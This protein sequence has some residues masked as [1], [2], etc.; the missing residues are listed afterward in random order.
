MKLLHLKDQTEKYEVKAID[1]LTISVKVYDIQKQWSNLQNLVQEVANDDFEGIVV[2]TKLGSTSDYWGLEFCMRLRLSYSL[3]GVKAFTTLFVYTESPVEEMIKEQ[4]EQKTQ[5]TA[6]LLLTKGTF[7]F[8]SIDLFTVISIPPSNYNQLNE[9]NYET[10]FL[11]VIRINKPPEVGHHSLANLFGATRLAEITG[12]RHLIDTNTA[13]SEKK[14]DLYFKF[15]TDFKS[16]VYK[17]SQKKTIQA[18]GKK[19]LLIDDKENFGWSD[20]LKEIFIGADFYSVATGENFVERAERQS[21]ELVNE[22]IK[23]DLILLDLRLKDEEDFNELVN[24]HSSEYSGAK[25]L[26]KIKGQNRGVQVIVFTAS[27]KA[28]NLKELIQAPYYADGYF[29]KESPEISI[30]AVFSTKAYQNFEIQVEECFIRKFLKILKRTVCNIKLQIK[31]SLWHDKLTKT[32]QL[33]IG[34]F[35]GFVISILDA[36]FEILSTINKIN[37]LTKL[38]HAFLLQYQILEEYVKLETIYQ[39]GKNKTASIVFKKDK[40]SVEVYGPDMQ[41]SGNVK[42]NIAFKKG[43][44]DYQTLESDQT[45]K[46]VIFQMDTFKIGVNS[47]SQTNETT[48]FKIINVFKERHHY[49]EVECNKLIELTYL[50]SNLCGHITGN[51]KLDK[52]DITKDDIIDLMNQI[53]NIVL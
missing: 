27:N 20:V 6:T 4:T 25:L 37:S 52:R 18:D 42:C 32:Q 51:V 44:F 15:K 3:I 19:I 17:G 22:V 2:S 14:T 46:A 35:E 24:K 34:N 16:N 33:E 1:G 21:L 7:A 43:K 38:R 48:L 45:I 26:K 39:V 36:T 31:K 13:I 49:S 10:A 50:R 11:D 8:D 12:N 5:P 29:I 23:W 40:T 28:W 30:D 53:G 9:G 47:K 41:L